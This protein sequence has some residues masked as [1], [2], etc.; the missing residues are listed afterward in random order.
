MEGGGNCVNVSDT[1]WR[2]AKGWELTRPVHG[3]PVIPKS[4]DEGD[5]SLKGS[6]LVSVTVREGE[7]EWVKEVPRGV[8]VSAVRKV[9][10]Q[11]L[12]WRACEVA[13]SIQGTEG[14]SLVPLWDAREF[15]DLGVAA[16]AQIGRAH[17]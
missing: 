14:E 3:E 12:G 10:A 17:V 4:V 13:M 11:L 9:V 6:R 2:M 7:R 8:S 5:R 1:K 15:G 16:T